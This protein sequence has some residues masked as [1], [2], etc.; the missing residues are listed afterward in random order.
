M[1]SS[2]RTEVEL[3]LALEQAAKE[4]AA[5][6]A[7]G[8][9]PFDQQNATMNVALAK[10]AEYEAEARETLKKLCQDN[11]SDVELKALAENNKGTL[12]KQEELFKHLEVE[13]KADKLG[14][15]QE[16]K[17]FR[18]KAGMEKDLLS[19]ALET[20]HEQALKM[21]AEGRKSAIEERKH[22]NAILE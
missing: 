19:E 1:S 7:Q 3:K 17:A 13:I 16:N 15:A 21:I 14:I 20:V 5:R 6:D 10:L 18:K 22:M 8:E 9:P 2:I 11:L 12:D 4:L